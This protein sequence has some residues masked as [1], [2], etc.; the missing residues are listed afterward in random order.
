MHKSHE[1]EFV[2]WDQINLRLP[3]ESYQVKSSQ[4]NLGYMIFFV[5]IIMFCIK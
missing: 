2:M 3:A 1:K 5:G 4:L